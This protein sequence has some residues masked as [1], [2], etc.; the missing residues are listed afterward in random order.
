ML[1]EYYILQ[2][3]FIAVRSDA[4]ATIQFVWRAS[5]LERNMSIKEALLVM[6]SVVM[7]EVANLNA[8]TDLRASSITVQR[9]V[10]IPHVC[11]RLHSWVQYFR[12]AATACQP[13]VRIQAW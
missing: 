10:I 13:V 8:Y 2:R 3:Y 4:T 9:H 6:I 1:G 12:D 11:S 7:P 5:A